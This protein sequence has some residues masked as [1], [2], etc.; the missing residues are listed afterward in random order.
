MGFINTSG[1]HSAGNFKN[2]IIGDNKFVI[3][4]IAPD[5]LI[6]D[7][8]VTKATKIGKIETIQLIPSDAPLINELNILVLFFIANRRIRTIN[9]GAANEPILSIRC[10]AFLSIDFFTK[11]TYQNHSNE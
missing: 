6:I 10:N 5:A 1:M 7:I 2:D 9:I 4:S 3:I 11:Y 8:D